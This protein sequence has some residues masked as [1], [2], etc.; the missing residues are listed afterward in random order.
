MFNQMGGMIVFKADWCGH[1]QRLLPELKKV[2]DITGLLYPIVL[3]DADKSP[4]LAEKAG[5]KGFPTVKFI[6]SKGYIQSD[7]KGGRTSSDILEVI[8]SKN[9][10][11]E[12]FCKF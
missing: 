1:C 7:Y 8:C 4:K 12:A 10:N 6:N 9:G 5:V 3:I 2:N 11:K